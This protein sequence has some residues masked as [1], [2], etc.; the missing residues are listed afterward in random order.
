M[1]AVVENNGNTAFIEFVN[2]TKFEGKI[3]VYV[4]TREKYPNI[5][6]FTSFGPLDKISLG[7]WF[8]KS[9]YKRK[10]PIT[11][12][13]IIATTKQE[14]KLMHHGWSPRLCNRYGPSYLLVSHPVKSKSVD[15]FVDPAYKIGGNYEQNSFE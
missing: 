4:S 11:T 5:K 2:I 7:I 12:V 9:R 13:K 6:E 14:K 10:S 8:D 15:L 3:L 1:K